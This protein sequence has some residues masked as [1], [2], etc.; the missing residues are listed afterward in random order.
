MYANCVM[1]YEAYVTSTFPDSGIERR[2]VLRA[3]HGCLHVVDVPAAVHVA[4][5]EEVL[6]ESL[7]DVLHPSARRVDGAVV[8][9]G[10]DRKLSLALPYDALSVRHGLDGAHVRRETRTGVSEAL[11]GGVDADR[12]RDGRALSMSARA[13]SSAVL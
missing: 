5:R 7:R 6:R 13:E 1:R 4:V 10:G 8:L 11:S 12:V 9:F 2:H 3:E